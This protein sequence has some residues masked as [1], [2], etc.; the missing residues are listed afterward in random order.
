MIRAE[1][2]SDALQMLVYIALWGSALLFDARHPKF[3]KS[4][5]WW[6]TIRFI[7][8]L[9]CF[10]VY[11][12]DSIQWVWFYPNRKERVCFP[13]SQYCPTLGSIFAETQFNILVFL[14]GFIYSAI[15][16]EPNMLSLV[17]FP[18]VANRTSSN[19]ARSH[20]SIDEK[21]AQEPK[22]ILAEDAVKAADGHEREA[23]SGSS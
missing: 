21:P 18:L 4:A 17:T 14:A 2:W 12:M 5:K 6:H 7:L 19:S 23:E 10:L 22:D 1:C 13:S 11:L 20:L 15:Y 8:P 3:N 9:L 16:M